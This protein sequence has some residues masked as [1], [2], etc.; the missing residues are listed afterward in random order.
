[1][2]VC[3]SV[4]EYKCI[5]ESVIAQEHQP[6]KELQKLHSL[7]SCDEAS[8]CTWHAVPH[9]VQLGHQEPTVH[10]GKGLCNIKCQSR[11]VSGIYN[12]SMKFKG[13]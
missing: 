6:L 1:M 11:S 3:V 10:G 9:F 2:C 13:V 12:L 7:G 5:S 8:S 4:L